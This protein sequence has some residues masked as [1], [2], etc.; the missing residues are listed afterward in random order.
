MDNHIPARKPDL[1]FIMKK[2]SCHFVDFAVLTD[3]RVKIKEFKRE[4]Y[5]YFSR[6]QKKLW[7]MKVT[8]TPIVLGVLGNVPRSLEKRPEEHEIKERIETIQFG[9]MLKSARKRKRIMRT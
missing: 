8:V 4:K 1:V 2:R 6:E 9:T 7:T 5:L 3:S